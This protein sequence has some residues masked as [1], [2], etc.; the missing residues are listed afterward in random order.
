MRFPYVI[1]DVDGTLLDTL[2][3]M[4]NSYL[5]VCREMGLTPNREAF[6]THAGIRTARVFLE[7][8]HMDA[9]DFARAQRI[10][11]ENY[12]RLAK[13][14]NELFPGVRE[15]L[16]ALLK[17]GAKICIATARQRRFI[18]E[19]FR[20]RDIPG[21][22]TH[23]SCTEGHTM[24]VDKREGILRCVHAM[25]ARPEACL[26]VGDRYLDVRGAKEAGVRACGVTYGFGSR[27]EM[28]A[29]GADY[30][31]DTVAQL[32]QLLLEEEP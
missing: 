12:E 14:N 13:S 1:F 24:H 9:A 26:M 18:G 6:L 28:L 11:G 10:Y 30:I 8:Y 31:V 19:M 4:E 17:K 21:M 5:A 16:E 29:E 20:E 27:R 32:R 25:G 2:D 22:F 15:M 3:G 7:H 23:I